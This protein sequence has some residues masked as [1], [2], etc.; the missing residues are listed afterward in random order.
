SSPLAI[1][2]ILRSVDLKLRRVKPFSPLVS[3]ILK[4]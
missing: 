3:C 4:S 2:R 1:S